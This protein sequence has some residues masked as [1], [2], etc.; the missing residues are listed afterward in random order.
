MSGVGNGAGAVAGAGTGTGDVPLSPKCQ[1]TDTQIFCKRCAKQK[2]HIF[3]TSLIIIP[4]NI[5]KIHVILSILVFSYA[6]G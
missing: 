5:S 1:C 3:T 6:K 2:N 4:V